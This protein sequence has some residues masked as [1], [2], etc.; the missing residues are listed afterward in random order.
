[1]IKSQRQSEILKL[2]ENTNTLLVADLAELLNC[3]MMT[4][5][6]DIEE[7]E[8]KSLVKKVFGGVELYGEKD[9][10]PNFKKRVARHIEEKR[11]I[12]EEAVKY[13]EK[14]SVVFVDAGS[15]PLQVV[16]IIPVGLKFTAIT[17]CIMTAAELCTKPNITVIMLG[18]EVHHSAYATVNNIAINTAKKFKTDLALI[19]THAVILPEGLFENTLSLIEIKRALVDN[20]KEVFLLADHSKFNEQAMC[21]SI[22]I[23]DIDHVITDKETPTDKIEGLRN[24][25]LKITQV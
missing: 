16:R 8:S 20:A 11:R 21:L 12:A 22:P 17:N 25:G 1:M 2:L 24:Q 6:R 9:I 3:S 15:T 14:G 10:E 19:S 18:G 7:M 23:T 4:I 5:R 13:I